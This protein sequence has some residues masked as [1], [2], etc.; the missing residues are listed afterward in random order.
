MINTIARV[1]DQAER[2]N[3]TRAARRAQSPAPA[4]VNVTLAPERADA[5]TNARRSS[6]GQ[7]QPTQPRNGKPRDG[8][9]TV[10]ARR[11]RLGDS[12]SMGAAGST[13]RNVYAGWAVANAFTSSPPPA[14]A[15]D[16]ISVVLHQTPSATMLFDN[17]PNDIGRERS[18]YCR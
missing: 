15:I 8:A 7:A 2:L 12:S 5:F 16:A 17:M 18:S 6:S 14:L 10:A 13:A 4:S 1:I 9:A 3:S 11:C